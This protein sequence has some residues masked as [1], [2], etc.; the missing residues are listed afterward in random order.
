MAFESLQEI[1][2]VCH[3]KNKLFWEVVLEED[4]AER[5]VTMQDSINKMRD[6]WDAMLLAAATYEPDLKSKSGLVGGDG[7]KMEVYGNEKAGDSLCGPFIDE[8]IAGAA[9]AKAVG[10]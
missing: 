3:A 8:V 7:H 4:I 1:V 5:D 10:G 2:A 9:G 6:T